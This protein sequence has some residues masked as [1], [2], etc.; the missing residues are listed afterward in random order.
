[1]CTYE[2]CLV[3]VYGNNQSDVNYIYQH[4]HTEKH[5]QHHFKNLHPTYTLGS[6]PTC[7]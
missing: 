2:C 6:P 1:M 5:L 3:G 7:I 4:F